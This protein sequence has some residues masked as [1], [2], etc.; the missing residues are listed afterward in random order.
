[1]AE[2]K[3]AAMKQPPRRSRRKIVVYISTSAD[4]YI[5]RADGTVDFLNERPRLKG[6]YDIGAFY[7]SI[8]TILW[9]RKTYDQALEFQRQGVTRAAFDPHIRHYAFSHHPPAASAIGVEFV[10]EEIGPFAKR[11]RA[12]RGKNVWMMGGAGIIGSFLDAGELDEF[13]INIVPVFIGE[14]IPL[15]APRHR[16]VPLALLSTK[17]YADGVIKLHYA[18]QRTSKK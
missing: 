3:F 17:K 13:I 6:H 12:S 8:D 1:V 7:R 18:V 15:I 5:A 9:G 16:R 4:G 10:T 14:G 2:L 11:L